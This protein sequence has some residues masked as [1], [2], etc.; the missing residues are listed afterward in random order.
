MQ[1]TERLS[2]LERWE[3]EYIYNTNIYINQNTENL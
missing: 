2:S 1:L 3:F